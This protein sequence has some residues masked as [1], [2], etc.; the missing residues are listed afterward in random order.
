M[1]CFVQGMLYPVVWGS[2]IFKTIPDAPGGEYLQYQV[3]SPRSCGRFIPNVDKYCIHSTH[4]GTDCRKQLS[5]DP[6]H[7]SS[8][9]K[10]TQ[11]PFA[12]ELGFHGSSCVDVV[13]IVIVAVQCGPTNS[14]RKPRKVPTFILAQDVEKSSVICQTSVFVA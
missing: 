2:S 8:E 1:G 6:N 10:R 14:T 9:K 4:L 7:G 5:S 13:F 12:N 3:I 11:S